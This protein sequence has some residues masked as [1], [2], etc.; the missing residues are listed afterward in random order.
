MVFCNRAQVAFTY[1]SS[2]GKQL[3]EENSFTQ[4]FNGDNKAE[5]FL[6]WEVGAT[7]NQLVS[8]N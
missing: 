5:Y 6:I 1:T 3:T 7:L 4:N 2:K 8:S